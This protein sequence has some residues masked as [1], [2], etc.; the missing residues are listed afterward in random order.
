MTPQRTKAIN[1]YALKLI[2]HLSQIGEIDAA[3]AV[4]GALVHSMIEIDGVRLVQPII[5]AE[6]REILEFDT[7]K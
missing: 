4:L 3:R 7:D 2:Y 1:F 5:A 6:A